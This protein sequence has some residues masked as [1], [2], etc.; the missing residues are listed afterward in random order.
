MR[1][2]HVKIAQLAIL[3]AVDAAASAL[4]GA[5]GLRRVSLERIKVAPPEPGATKVWVR[6]TGWR[7]DKGAKALVD[8]S[9]LLSVRAAY[10]S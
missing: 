2:K 4:K 7:S 10:A 5:G 3:G 1:I 8:V 9:D 6:V